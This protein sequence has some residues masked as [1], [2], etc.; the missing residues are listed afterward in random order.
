MINVLMGAMARP[1]N[2][3]R[4]RVPFG[5]PTFGGPVRPTFGQR[6]MF[7]RPGNLLPPLRGVGPM[8]PFGPAR[9]V[10]PIGP[11]RPTRLRSGWEDFPR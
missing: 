4:P 2:Y 8:Q 3:L 6:P 5:G 1:Q 9:P 7:G 11:A 10:R